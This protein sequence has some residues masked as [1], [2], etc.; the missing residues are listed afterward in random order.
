MVTMSLLPERRA[1]I[2]ADLDAMPDD[3]RR[4]EL[5]D[6]TLIVTPAPTV[7]HQVA[8]T[9]LL[10]ILLGSCPD[11]L[12]VLSAPTDVVL[13]VDTT[14][15]PDVLVVERA[16]LH[17]DSSPL[18]PLLAIE[19]L[20]PSTRHVDLSLKKARLEV[21]GCPSYWV[22]DVE[23]PSITAWTLADSGYGEPV[24][25]RGADLFSPTSPFDTSF[26]PADLVL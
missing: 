18:V 2:G 7:R 20:S 17:Q 26:A 1:L 12:Y 6:G 23:V 21:A 16:S 24:V 25:T 19:V 15:Q 22:V 4:Y 5:I 13:A 10:R 9:E 11:N 14:L 8:V 3:G